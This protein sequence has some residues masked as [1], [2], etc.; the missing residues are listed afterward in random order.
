ML[1]LMFYHAV[2]DAL[3]DS[4]TRDGADCT[5]FGFLKKYK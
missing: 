3:A 1:N 4:F 5:S 2:L